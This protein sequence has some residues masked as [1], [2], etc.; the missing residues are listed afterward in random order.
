MGARENICQISKEC[1]NK[2]KILKILWVSCHFVKF[3]IRFLRLLEEIFFGV[4]TGNYNNYYIY[5]ALEKCK[6]RMRYYLNYPSA[7]FLS[8]EN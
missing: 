5:I 7:R 8:T 3:D 6:K 1:K 4:I 2:G